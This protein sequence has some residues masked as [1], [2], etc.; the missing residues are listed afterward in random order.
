MS[1][2]IQSA[3]TKYHRLRGLQMEIFSPHSTGVWEVQDQ[4]SSIFEIL[5]GSASQYLYSLLLTLSHMDPF[6]V[7]FLASE[8]LRAN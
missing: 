5:H 1:V 2:L 6:G 7:T 8:P 4:G 3:T